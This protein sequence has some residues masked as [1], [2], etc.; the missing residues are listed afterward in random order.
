VSLAAITLCF[1]SHCVFV[2]IV[3]VYFVIHSIR[4]ILDTPTLIIQQNGMCDNSIVEPEM[5]NPKCVIIFLYEL[6]ND[7]YNSMLRNQISSVV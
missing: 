5:K 3:V 1:A 4:K 2:V 7:D 6:V